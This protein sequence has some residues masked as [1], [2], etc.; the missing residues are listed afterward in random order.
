MENI[1]KR[2]SKEENNQYSFIVN[3]KS[4]KCTIKL[5]IEDLFKKEK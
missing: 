2:C 5:A 4:D 1:S 3:S